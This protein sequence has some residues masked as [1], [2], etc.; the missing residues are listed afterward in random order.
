M[1]YI[2]SS[3]WQLTSTNYISLL[4]PTAQWGESIVGQEVD[5]GAP[6]ARQETRPGGGV[7]QGSE[8][9]PVEIQIQGEPLGNISWWFLL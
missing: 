8:P 9:G 5:P 4:S 1:M 2:H 6:S 7:L 3:R